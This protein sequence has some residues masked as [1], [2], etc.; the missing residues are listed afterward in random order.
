MQPTH[1]LMDPLRPVIVQPGQGNDLHAFGD[2][3]S[4]MLAGEQTGSA[5]TVMFDI[6]PPGGGPPLHV[7][8]REDELFL[9]VEGR[10]SYFAEN[11]WTEVEPGGAVF[12]P[13]GSIHTYRNIG[14]AP[15][16]HWIITA[17]SGFEKFF[18]CCAE[19]FGKSGGPEMS[20]I[21]E[22]HR[23]YGIEILG[24]PPACTM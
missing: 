15:S 21:T 9:V 16:K 11:H 7:H 4:V 8:S 22:I 14:D 6:T 17:P 1:Y 18:A 5:L 13:R 20:R 3:L 12:L 23:D 24:D 2:L 19:E 10:L